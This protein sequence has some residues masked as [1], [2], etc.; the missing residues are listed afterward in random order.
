MILKFSRTGLG[1]PLVILH[2]LYG[3]GDN[4]LT[5]ARGLSSVCEVF[6]VDQRNH[7]GSFHSMQHD[8]PSLS[9]DVKN[10]MDHLGLDK[11]F[12][13]GH[14]MGGRTAMRFAS[15]HPGRLSGLIIADISPR[16]YTDPE[17]DAN[18]QNYHQIILKA[19]SKVSLEG[20]TR[21]GDAENQLA[22]ILPDRRLRQFLLKNLERTPTGVFRWKLN[23]PALLSNLDS[24]NSG[25]EEEISK[26]MTFTRFPV[27][28]LR[29]GQSD[30][31]RDPDILLIR[32]LYPLAQIVTLKNAGHWLHAEQP[33][34]FITTVK[35]FLRY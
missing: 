34:A 5:I 22:G 32:K 21:I 11:A 16:S 20:I 26:G 10:L 13:L 33:A 9:N 8:Y 24:L 3:S 12:I 23:I 29:G 19:L 6:L 14:S 31:I 18:H 28:F 25:M 17:L 2:G 30:Y 27:L 4:W 1:F 35:T 7:G 15:D